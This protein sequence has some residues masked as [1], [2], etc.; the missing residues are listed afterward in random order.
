[1]ALLRSGLASRQP[2]PGRPDGQAA[3][4]SSAPGG[5]RAPPQAPAAGRPDV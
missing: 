1:V 4:D 2:G 5:R 3:G